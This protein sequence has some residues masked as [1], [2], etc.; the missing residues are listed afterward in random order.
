MIPVEYSYPKYKVDSIITT[1]EVVTTPVILGNI[2][3]KH[4]TQKRNVETG[5]IVQS[6]EMMVNKPIYGEVRQVM[7]VDT[8]MLQ[9]VDAKTGRRLDNFGDISNIGFHGTEGYMVPGETNPNDYLP[10]SRM[11]HKRK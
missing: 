1:P 2:A 7:P 4:M 6:H 10:S 8:H 9:Y 3:E 5:Q 11:V